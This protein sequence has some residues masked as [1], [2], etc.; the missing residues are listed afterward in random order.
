MADA[1]TLL[2]PSATAQERAIEQAM[3]L[4]EPVHA[5]VEALLTFKEAPPDSALMWLVW[6]YGLQDLLPYLPDARSAIAHGIV[7]QRIKGTPASV[8]MALAWLNYGTPALEEEVPSGTH[9]SEYMVDPGGVPER[10]H[11]ISAKQLAYL[12]APVGTVLSRIYHEYDVRRFMLDGSQFGDLLSD[13]SGV[14]DDD[15]GLVLSFGRT[16]VSA[17]E[18]GDQAPAA[19]TQTRNHGAHNKYDDRLLWDFSRF[20]DVPVKNHQIMHGHLFQI[21]GQG[22]QIE[23]YDAE[24]MTQPKAAIILSDGFVLGETNAALFPFEYDETGTPQPLSA[25]M[26]LS[27]EPWRIVK[28]PVDERFERNTDTAGAYSYDATTAGTAGATRMSFA[29]TPTDTEQS[30]AIGVADITSS[31]QIS[32]QFWTGIPWAQATWADLQFNVR[33]NQYGDLA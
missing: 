10:A 4:P 21:I 26:A 5:G 7:W 33:T 9:W 23:Q 20:G 22:V 18:L 17:V 32:G 14:R 1:P 30:N 25:G 27:G 11:L 8:R 24:G 6:E 28:R 12:S 2:P 13:H 29:F 3:L 16:G 19:A 31:A 15:L